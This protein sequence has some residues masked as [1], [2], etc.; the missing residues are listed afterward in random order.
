MPLVGFWEEKFPCGLTRV[1]LEGADLCSTA[2]W[3]QQ[4]KYYDRTAS[5]SDPCFWW[6]C[7]PPSLEEGASCSVLGSTWKS[8]SRAP[9]DGDWPKMLPSSLTTHSASPN[10]CFNR[11]P[12]KGLLE[13]PRNMLFT[14]SPLGELSCRPTLKPLLTKDFITTNYTV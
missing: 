12:G 1:W 13:P 3:G 7:D 4:P 14:L 8:W 10:S 11:G 9:S 2:S 6:P 5:P